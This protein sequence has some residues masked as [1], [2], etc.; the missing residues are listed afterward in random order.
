[1]LSNSHQ[2]AI[3]CDLTIFVK[4]SLDIKFKVIYLH[5]ERDCDI[6]VVLINGFQL[7]T[8]SC[9]DGSAKKR[10]EVVLETLALHT[11]SRL[12]VMIICDLNARSILA[13]NDKSN[14]AGKIIDDFIQSH[15]GT[16]HIVND[17]KM[18]FHRQNR[19]LSILDLCIMSDKAIEYV[20]D[21][22][23]CN[24]FESDHFSILVSLR[25]TVSQRLKLKSVHDEDFP[26]RACNIRNDSDE[27]GTYLEESFANLFQDN[28]PELISSQDLWSDMEFC[29]VNS[30]QRCGF[31]SRNLK[32][33]E[34]SG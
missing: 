23:T 8:A 9:Q 1:M 27:F 29:I 18:K 7:V 20:D 12:P 11:D 25:V 6:A 17:G 13:G 10:K 21:C 4:D 14:T 22:N 26:V 2:V 5:S 15:D 28:D 34:K 16:F 33:S 24:L 19:T 31:S 3:S 32:S 30:L